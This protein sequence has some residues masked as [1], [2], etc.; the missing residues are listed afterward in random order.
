M[1]TVLLAAILCAAPALAAPRAVSAA[2]APGFVGELQRPDGGRLADE[3]QALRSYD[4]AAAT[5]RRA[6]IDRALVHLRGPIGRANA[7]LDRAT[8]RAAQARHER[9]DVVLKMIER[10][11]A[12]FAPERARSD[13]EIARARTRERLDREIPRLRLAADL[14]LATA[15]EELTEVV[16]DPAGRGSGSGTYHQ[17]PC[18]AQPGLEAWPALDEALHRLGYVLLVGK[19]TDDA[20]RVY[21]RIVDETPRSP[22]RMNAL[23]ELADHAFDEADLATAE[24]LYRAALAAPAP[25]P[26]PAAPSLRA[27]ATY[28]LA[29]VLLNL[30]HGRDAFAALATVP[31]LATAAA[32][33]AA[34][35]EKTLVHAA[36]RDL[37]HV[38]AAYGAPADALDALEAAAPGHGME[39]TLRVGQ[40]WLEVRRPT[41]AIALYRELMRRAPADPRRCE[42]QAAVASG[43]QATGDLDALIPELEALAA[44]HLEVRG[45]PAGARCA[46]D[47]TAL[48]EEVA[49]KQLSTAWTKRGTPLTAEY[50]ERLYAAYVRAFPGDANVAAARLHRA[51]AASARAEKASGAVAAML[52]QRAA[53]RFKEALKAGGLD[54]DQ[55][56]RALRYLSRARQRA[57]EP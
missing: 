50:A 7:R 42:W 38:F 13:R 55:R 51:E 44:A 24:S 37:A 12:R 8:L 20:V 43:V 10:D 32:A 11:E 29:W 35:A 56:D 53:A 39:L 46:I 4:A 52:W 2:P 26:A 3:P 45:E 22:H 16:C 31:A 33:A 36:R 18:R 54:E 21:R 5:R 14:T 23:V 27:Y 34:A 1:R 25:T 17:L 48:I 41:D 15:I 57:A 28:K 47:A 6:E 9:F 49:R 30:G 19:R 40:E